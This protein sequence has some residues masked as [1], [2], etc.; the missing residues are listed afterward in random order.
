MT[1]PHE[2]DETT[3]FRRCFYC[4]LM[5]EADTLVPD[6]Q[7]RDLCPG[8]AKALANKYPKR[9]ADPVAPR[10]PWHPIESDLG[11]EPKP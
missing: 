2:M 5:C 10:Y 3:E 4:G 1:Y 11:K 6:G 7:L 9:T 8:C